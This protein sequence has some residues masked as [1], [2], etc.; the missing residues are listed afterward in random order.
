VRHRKHRAGPDGVVEPGMLER[1]SHGNREISSLATGDGGPH[2]EGEE[3]KPMKNGLEKS[4]RLIV[5]KKPA[6]SAKGPALESVER[7]R[8]TKENTE[9]A[10]THRTLSRARVFPGLDRVRERARREKKDR[11]TSLLHHVNVELLEAAFSW[12]RR[13]AAPGADG[14]TWHEYEQDLTER[15][16]DLHERLH[17]GVYRPLP[18]RRKFIP[19]GSGLRPLGVA[20]LED[21]VVQ[22]ALVEV[23]N[24]IYETDFLGFSYGFRSGRS[25]HDALDAIAFGITRMRVNHVLDCD[26]RAFFDSLSHEWL[27]RFLEHRVGDP[28]VIRLIR[29]WLKA[30]VVVDGTLAP[31]EAGTPQ[32]AV[33]SPLLANIYLHYCFDQWAERWRQ[34]DARGQVIFV[35]YADDI[36]AG[37]EHE[38]D[39]RRFQADVHVRLERFALTLHP[40]KTR[41]LE[42]GRFAADN[43]AKR[44]VSR[45]ETFDFLGFKHI[46][47]HSLAGYFQLKRKTRRDRMR[48][49][50]QSVKEELRRRR[51]DPIPDQ[52]R[53]LA[54]VVRGYF[55]YHAVPTN[56]RSLVAFRGDIKVLWMRA[57]RKRSQKDRT[58]WLRMARLVADYLPKP[59]ILHPWP[60][61][62][63]LV[64]HPRWKP[65][66]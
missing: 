6:N 45:P 52:G 34:R 8:R 23:L 54:Q 1:S 31:S 61:D 35:R 3:P 50:L 32:G 39:A 53:W 40:E 33:I 58:S 27:I 47:G 65:S 56:G 43:R 28:R 26:I 55:A 2:R 20:A 17:R 36:V 60:A 44:G 12:L 46:S 14:M 51:H 16:R 62:R 38:E 15:L 41:L 63:F 9:D 21:K 22:R 18:S 29:G 5:A 30:G 19:K 7:R 48:A 4:D 64:K 25:Q 42:F 24:A 13:D 49:T 59:K 66:A 11:F 57:L 10:C 37:F